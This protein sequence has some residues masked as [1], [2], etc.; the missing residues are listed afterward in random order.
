MAAPP[1]YMQDN[2]KMLHTYF[3]TLSALAN[4]HVACIIYVAVKEHIQYFN[5]YQLIT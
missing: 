4:I 1:N 5:T 3:I 2:V